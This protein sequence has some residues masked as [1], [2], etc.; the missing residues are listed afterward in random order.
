MDLAPGLSLVVKDAG[1]GLTDA[2]W[3]AVEKTP[4]Q[5]FYDSPAHDLILDGDKILGIRARQ[6]TGYVDFPFGRIKLPSVTELPMSETDR[7]PI[8][9]R[10]P[11]REFGLTPSQPRSIPTMTLL[12]LQRVSSFELTRQHGKVVV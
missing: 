4:I 2:M 1:V 3:A 10:R 9:W 6:S 11:W 8:A 5:V 12:E 7:A